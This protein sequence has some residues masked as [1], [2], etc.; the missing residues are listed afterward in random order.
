MILQALK[1]RHALVEQHVRP[2]AFEIAPQRVDREIFLVLEVIEERSL[3]HAGGLGDVLD[4]TSLETEGMQRVYRAAGELLAQAGSGHG[5]LSRGIYPLRG[6]TNP[7]AS[8]TNMRLS[9]LFQC[10]SLI[11]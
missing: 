11:N 2:R 1:R 8:M 5:R 10:Y 7:L 3:G 4:R 6:M 9:D